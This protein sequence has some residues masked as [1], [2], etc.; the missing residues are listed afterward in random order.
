MST[1]PPRKGPSP[2][3]PRWS[4]LDLAKVEGT[5]FTPQAWTESL[6]HYMESAL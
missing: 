6:E 4:T 3:A 2:R 1:T 5:G